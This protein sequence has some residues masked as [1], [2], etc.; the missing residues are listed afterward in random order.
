MCESKS[1][2]LID[3]SCLCVFLLSFSP[4][5]LYVAFCTEQQVSYATKQHYHSVIIANLY[6]IQRAQ[7]KATVKD[8]LNSHVSMRF[9]FHFPITA[10]ISVAFSPQQQV[11]NATK[12]N[13]TI[14]SLW[15]MFIKCKEQKSKQ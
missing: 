1:I 8:E 11:S 7:I 12:S 5:S 3:N 15:P 14:Q 4:I 13:Q 2:L 10:C 6:Q 9:I